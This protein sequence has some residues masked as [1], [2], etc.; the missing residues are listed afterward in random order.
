MPP[1]RLIRPLRPWHPPWSPAQIRWVS[2]GARDKLPAQRDDTAPGG[3]G[4]ASQP[5]STGSADAGEEPSSSQKASDGTRWGGVV[6][7]LSTLLSK[8]PQPI[9]STHERSPKSSTA[10]EHRFQTDNHREFYEPT[11]SKPSS[12]TTC[13]VCQEAFKTGRRT[14]PSHNGPRRRI[15]RVAESRYRQTINCV[16]ETL[17]VLDAISPPLARSHTKLVRAHLDRIHHEAQLAR[18]LALLGVFGRY[19]QF[20]KRAPQESKPKSY[21][22]TETSK[23]IQGTSHRDQPQHG[24]TKK[25]SMYEIATPE[26]TGAA[27][28][29]K[30]L[31]SPVTGPQNAPAIK[32]NVLEESEGITSSK[33]RLQERPLIIR[34]HY[35]RKGQGPKEQS[36]RIAKY[37]SWKGQGKKSMDADYSPEKSSEGIIPNL[38]KQEP[39]LKERKPKSEKVEPNVETNA[40]LRLQLQQLIEQVKI[41]QEKIMTQPIPSPGSTQAP[42]TSTIQASIASMARASIPDTTQNYNVDKTPDPGTMQG[43]DDSKIET[44]MPIASTLSTSERRV[45]DRSASLT[46]IQQHEASISKTTTI[47][48]S[49]SD[50]SK[51]QPPASIAL[52]TD[53]QILVSSPATNSTLKSEGTTSRTPLALERNTKEIASKSPQSDVFAYLERAADNNVDG[54]RLTRQ[55][56]TQARMMKSSSSL[57]IGTGLSASTST[58]SKDEVSGSPRTSA[59]SDTSEMSERSLLD[60]LFPEASNYTQPHY[61]KRNPYPKLNPPNSAPLVRKYHPRDKMTDREKFVEAFQNK[62]DKVTALQLLHCSI[63]LTESDFRRLVPKGRHIESW[64]RD[65]EFFKVIPGRDPLSLERLPFYYLL[66]KNPEA[67]LRYQNNAVRLHKLSQLH[68]PSSA[69]SAI[70]PPRGFLENGEDIDAATSSYLLVPAN[71]TLQLNMLMQ[72]YNS[73]LGRLI[74]DG[75]YKPIVPSTTPAGKKI[76]RVLFHIEGYEPSAY[77]LFQLFLQD[78]FRRGFTWPFLHE[79]QSIHRLRDIIDLKT[80][81]LPVSSL[82]P[83]SANLSKRKRDA[84]DDPAMSWMN[85]WGRADDDGAD[86]GQDSKEINQIIMNKVYNRW[87]V[88]FSEEHG[89]RRFARLWNRKVLPMQESRRH[90]TWRDLEEVRMCNAEYLW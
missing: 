12:K 27:N 64:A 53:K 10:P 29:S 6:R 85:D 4:E 58:T 5:I 61:T 31:K 57:N 21:S 89:A 2:N 54:Q 41:L 34:T 88:E 63:E 70:P 44:A 87:V 38:E 78:A 67:A 11:S 33:V 83:R 25:T 3:G 50:P 8:P 75:G 45:E 43:T 35:T 52:A 71:Q 37:I 13:S 20:S 66:F 26:K 59:L 46:T 36:L 16:L 86:D 74:E 23:G 30:K 55:I 48:Q 24:F 69:L 76:H 18:D 7:R 80:K 19:A 15:Q 65:G 40:D 9:P 42:H 77:D 39:N 56:H 32:E 68:Q 90:I 49:S 60:E 73:A 81:F 82:N 47:S 1:P 72:P 28:S 14:V 51:L 62:S 17:E 84:Y 79:H 22:S